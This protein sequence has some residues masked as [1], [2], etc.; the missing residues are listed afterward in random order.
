MFR[1]KKS[2]YPEYPNIP[3][4]HVN[5]PDVVVDGSDTS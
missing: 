5:S 1:I 2:L 3:K 4:I